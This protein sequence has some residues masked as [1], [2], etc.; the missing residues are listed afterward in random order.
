MIGGDDGRHPVAGAW[1]A[2]EWAPRRAVVRSPTSERASEREREPHETRQDEMTHTHR[3]T[4]RERERRASLPWR[5][6]GEETP[7]ESACAHHACAHHACAHH[8]RAHHRRPYGNSR[9]T[10]GRSS[11]PVDGCDGSDRSLRVR[12]LLGAG[13]ARRGRARVG[14]CE[15]PLGGRQA[16]GYGQVDVRTPASCMVT[17]KRGASH[18]TAAF[19]L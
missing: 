8:A 5:C 15:A 10:H 4:Q 13:A 19:V 11:S 7:D 6:S 14:G 3:H 12:G 16:K 2:W 9:R 17:R 1:G 18:G